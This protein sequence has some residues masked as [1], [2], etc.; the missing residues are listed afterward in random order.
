MRGPRRRFAASFVVTL[1]ALP[2]CGRTVDHR[3]P[4]GPTPPPPPADAAPR[5][6]R[7]QPTPPPGM[8]GGPQTWSIVTMG[9]GSCAAEANIQCPPPD[10]GT[11]N[12]PPPI[13]ITCPAGA[14]QGGFRIEEQAD[15]TC[16]VL[17]PMADCPAGMSCNPPPPRQIECPKP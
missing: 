11:C 17:A 10:V 15:H 1:A 4:V 12:P 3:D 9:D 14:K 6:H 5:D 7:D 16:I 13:T 2:A 8:G